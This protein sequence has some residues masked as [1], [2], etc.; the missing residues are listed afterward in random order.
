M[1]EDDRLNPNGSNWIRRKRR[2]EIYERDGWRCVYCLKDLRDVKPR[3]RTLDHV[4]PRVYRVD[5]AGSNLVTCC[6]PCNDRKSHRDVLDHVITLP[7]PDAAIERIRERTGIDL[8]PIP[9]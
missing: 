9:F 5:N 3:Q 8:Q 1:G 4:I 2:L 7:D 6:R